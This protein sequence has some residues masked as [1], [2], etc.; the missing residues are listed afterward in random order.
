MQRAQIMTVPER[1]I[2]KRIHD[3]DLICLLQLL[4]FLG[5][6]PE[7]IQFKSHFSNSSQPSL[8]RDIAFHHEPIRGVLI[9]LNLGLLGP[10]S[11]LPS[12]FVKRLDTSY[13]DTRSFVDFIG[14]F[15]HS[16]I[17]NYLLNIY[18]ETNTAFFPNLQLTRLRFLQMLDLKSCSTLH[19]LFQL[20]FPELGVR[21]E[22]VVFNRQLRTAHLRLGETVLGTDP[23]FGEKTSVPVHGN[24]VTLLSEFETTNSGE[25][26][27][28]EI[29]RRLNDLI[30]PILGSI[31]M[32]LE[33]L[34]IIR[35]QKTWAK[36]H[37]E[38]YLGYDKIR[39]GK[40]HYRRIQIFMGRIPDT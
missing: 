1:N 12:Y 3:F 23:I 4:Q 15:D 16:L 33:I 30:F 7:E 25:P 10:Q 40:E 29:N 39:G 9:T 36:L 24:S 31:G 19:W 21:A 11:P 17:K 5:Y 35:T 37:S 32:D 28:R 14:Y 6:Q 13:F 26:W 27:P 18:P 20:V 2:A 34:L 22:K 8:I 38:S